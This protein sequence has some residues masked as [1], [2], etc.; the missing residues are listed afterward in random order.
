MGIG[1]K[2]SF[3]HGWLVTFPLP[4][5]KRSVLQEMSVTASGLLLVRFSQSRLESFLSLLVEKGSSFVAF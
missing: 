5:A 1:M 3:R 2:E 4:L